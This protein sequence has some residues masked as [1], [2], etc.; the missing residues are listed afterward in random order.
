MKSPW[1]TCWLSPTHLR[2]GPPHNPTNPRISRSSHFH[3]PPAAARF[4]CM[5]PL[6]LY[7]AAAGIIQCLHAQYSRLA[8]AHGKAGRWLASAWYTHQTAC[9]LAVLQSFTSAV[10]KQGSSLHDTWYVRGHGNTSSPQEDGSVT[11]HCTPVQTILVLR[12][13][14]Q[15]LQCML[16]AHRA[17]FIPT[18]VLSVLC[19][20]DTMQCSDSYN[21]KT[22][23]FPT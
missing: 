9:P 5:G 13:V 8:C 4:C 12:T 15:K 2:Y 19:T 23:I 20:Y 11:A 21:I 22:V 6:L 16:L 1:S 7:G 18:T 3:E 17:L 10:C 14:Y